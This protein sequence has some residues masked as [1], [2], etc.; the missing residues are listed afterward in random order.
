M[1]E[2]KQVQEEALE[3]K[4]RET[5]GK[6]LENKPTKESRTN[7]EKR[8]TDRKEQIN[9]YAEENQK[10]EWNGK[11]VAQKVHIESEV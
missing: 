10:L 5:N 9:C 4:R 1:E 3:R 8:R 6:S 7:E 11:T 2:E